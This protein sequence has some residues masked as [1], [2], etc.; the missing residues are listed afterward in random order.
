MSAKK[1]IGSVT[2]PA[3]EY[4]V[5]DP[6]YGIPDEE[7]IPWLESA[8]Y[9]KEGQ[10]LLA[11]CRDVWCVGVS[12]AYGDGLFFDDSG[13]SYPVD[14]GLIGAVP[15]SL[16]ATTPQGM[17]LVYFDR[18]FDVSVDEDGLISI[19][20]IKIWTGEEEEEEGW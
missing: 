17:H 16:S 9:E 11:K 1:N 13:L 3:G 8:D 14:A 20:H 4:Y 5:G 2:M 12:T 10:Y 7:W 6:C 15:K 19:G 18:D